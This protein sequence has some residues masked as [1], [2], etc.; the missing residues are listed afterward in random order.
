MILIS[1]VKVMVIEKKIYPSVKE[2]LNKIKPYL[3]D[4]IIDLK[5]SRTWKVQLTIAVKFVLMNM[6]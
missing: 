2:Y 4:T 6:V 3:S 5:K 1:N